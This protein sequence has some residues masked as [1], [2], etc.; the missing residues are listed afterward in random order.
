ME[1][2]VTKNVTI[3]KVKTFDDLFF[4]LTKNNHWNFLNTRMMEAMVTASMVLAAQKSLE[5]L[6]N[7]IFSINLMKYYLTCQ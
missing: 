1:E 5:N 6:K 7:T 4:T 3:E 2:A